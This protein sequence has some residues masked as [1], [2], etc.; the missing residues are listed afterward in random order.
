MVNVM[1]LGRISNN[2]S[3][4]TKQINGEIVKVVVLSEIDITNVKVLLKSIDN[5]TICDD[6][7]NSTVTKFYPKNTIS[8][9]QEQVHIENYFVFGP[10][11]V[12]IIGLG[13]EEFI[14]DIL[15]YYK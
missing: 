2:G 8:I 7:L 13:D 10:L 12:D 15:V 9:S 3:G 11:I 1:K 6:Y 4:K 14:E 5:E